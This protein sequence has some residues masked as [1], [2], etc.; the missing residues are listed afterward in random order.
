[1]AWL[2]LPTLQNPQHLVVPLNMDADEGPQGPRTA[3]AETS[4][5]DGLGVLEDCEALQAEARNGPGS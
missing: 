1:M 4:G 3:H 5:L 2:S